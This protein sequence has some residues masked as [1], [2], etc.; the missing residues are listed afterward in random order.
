MPILFWVE[1]AAYSAA[2]LSA[3]TLGLMVLATAPR[4]LLNRFFAFIAILEAIWAV[5][6]VL[7]RI[8]LL[9][10]IGNATF[11]LEFA[12][13]ALNVIGYILPAFAIRYVGRRSKR[14]DIFVLLGFVAAA[15]V[16]VPTFRGQILFNPNLAANGIAIYDVTQWGYI[17]PLIPIPYFILSFVILWRD[18][19]EAKS[20]YLALSTLVLLIGFVLGGILRSVF[21][22]P[23]LS[24]TVALSV[25]VMGYGIIKNQL[26][27]PL[28]ELAEQLEQKVAKRTQELEISR[29][30]L[31]AQTRK[32]ERRNKYLETTATVIQ[33]VSSVLQPD[34]LLSEITNL[35][36]ERLKLFRVG[37]FLID[38]SKEWA[39]LRAAA[40]HG[41][42]K[43]LVKDEFRLRINENGT[44]AHVIQTGLPYLTAD[45]TQEPIYLQVDKIADTRSELTVPLR[46]R[47]EIM[48]A[49]SIQSPEI[50]T[51]NEEDITIM[52]TLADQ[53]ALAISNAQLFQQTQESLEI[54]RR[55]YG[56]LSREAWQKLLRGQDS[57]AVLRDESGVT[58]I[59]EWIDPEVKQVLE[60][61]E[62][63]RSEGNATKLGVPIRVRG[64]VIGAIDVHKH[65]GAGEWNKEQITLVE[66]LASQVGEALE[67]ARLYQETQRRA[68]RERTASDITAKMRR[69]AGVERI[70]QTALDEL[71]ETL[72]TSRAF[73]Q[74]GTTPNQNENP[75]EDK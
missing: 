46:A 67:A 44:V 30:A 16:M 4:Q 41:A 66:T 38:P 60:T 10:E 14:V 45:T 35:I 25:G 1:I 74:L 55:A 48:G 24:I 3:F 63:I 71:Y 73:I 72:G 12:A 6:A 70:V 50:D 23:I 33:E 13:I 56:E 61:G 17:A 9:L 5:S 31:A 32:M 19:H 75:E 29:D 36:T 69:A 54:E 28:K 15:I 57:I 47:G 22:L 34:E 43:E 62:I 21:P 20:T 49:L 40:G 39:V 52:Q 58:Q 2:T 65:E 26:F 37:L 7:L 53:V 18:R 8:D 68:A 59:S 51:F 42:L 64:Q 27:N 11:W